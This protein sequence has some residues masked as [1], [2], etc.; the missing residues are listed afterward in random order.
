MLLM[1]LRGRCHPEDGKTGPG[2]GVPGEEMDFP[3]FNV[4][5]LSHLDGTEI[6]SAARGSDLWGWTDSGSG[7]E[8]AI[9]GFQDGTSIVDISVP[10]A[11]VYLGFLPSHTAN[12]AWRDIKTY[13]HFAY[14]VSDTNR[15]HGLQI[16]DLTAV[17]AISPTP[18]VLTETS[19]FSGFSSAHNIAINEASGFAYAVGSELYRGGLVMIDLRQPLEPMIVGGYDGD[20]YTHD[21]QVVIYHGPDADFIGREIA[22]NANEDTL[23]VVDVSDKSEPVLVARTSYP[24]NGYAH[25]GWLTEDQGYFLLNDEL[26]ELRFATV[27]TTR[28]HIFDVRDLDDV[29]YLGLYQSSI[30]SIDHNHYT[31]NGL[32]YQANYT[33]GLRVL[34]LSDVGNVNLLEVGFFDTHPEVDNTS[35]FDGA[36]SVF[37]Y[38]GSGSII[39]ADRERGLFVLELDINKGNQPTLAAASIHVPETAVAGAIAGTINVDNV[40]A[41]NSP[42]FTMDG[43][44]GAALFAIDRNTGHITL[45]DGAVLDFESTMTLELIVN[46]SVAGAPNLRDRQT[47]QI[48]VTDVNEAPI[49]VDDAIHTDEDTVVSSPPL[50]ANDYDPDNADMASIDDD[51]AVI[52]IDTTMT[53]GSV[54]D[55]GG[56]VVAYDP[57]GKFES[58]NDGETA[59]DR[60][61]YTVS[62]DRGGTSVG[63]V[64]VQI[65]GRTDP[66]PWY[67]LVAPS[68]YHGGDIDATG[69]WLNVQICEVID[70]LPGPV[71]FATSIP[72]SIL[73]PIGYVRA[74][75]AG[76]L[77]GVYRYQD[78]T[79]NP[80]TNTF[81]DWRVST[82]D[83]AHSDTRDLTVEYGAARVKAVPE[84]TVNLT[85]NGT[86]E[87][88]AELVYAQG[89]EVQI[90][91]VV[92]PTE[93]PRVIRRL[94]SPDA[95]GFIPFNDAIAFTG[96]LR[97]GTYVV[98]LRAF[99]PLSAAVPQPFVVP[100]GNP[101]IVTSAEAQ[102]VQVRV[103]PEHPFPE[104]GAVLVA[105]GETL[106]VAV[107]WLSVPGAVNYVIYLADIAKG[108][109]LNYTKILND[110]GVLDTAPPVEVELRPGSY[111]WSACAVYDD[112][113]T[114]GPWLP[115][116]R[117]DIVSDLMQP[118]ITN[119]VLVDACSDALLLHMAPGGGAAAEVEMYRFDAEDGWIDLGSVA[120]IDGIAV[121]PDVVFRPGDLIQLRAVQ[122]DQGDSTWKTF[123][124]H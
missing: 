124:L 77:P 49:T 25:Q 37:P 122:V 16:L 83:A 95:D 40:V 67:P 73:R 110:G 108:P 5:L 29:R 26:D 94:Y 27:A 45:R 10:A 43:G 58:L 42:I 81:G 84:P 6:G 8:I 30:P 11:P 82:P 2:S 48:S 69:S 20:G 64:S 103:A 23:T 109:V 106:S 80:V 53:L 7:R 61:Q 90:T 88:N 85:G 66:P 46:V 97:P 19:H 114:H 9:M 119:V 33:S 22:F 38:Y 79:W 54:I 57:N 71:V 113:A 104:T 78:R 1:P 120:V 68:L 63:N 117:F 32:L 51:L 56:G 118:L 18:A 98:A 105:H 72:G 92:F 4:R 41:G 12:S 28:T 123:T 55:L 14:I 112:R 44:T 100:T 75:F 115:A 70:G 3:A 116:Q 59:E 21:T 99:N 74:G 91:D 36:W 17:L 87:L 34:D 47:V 52:A 107:N 31:H 13:R 39:V 86:F 24:E 101:L 111:L 15:D 102:D 89:F 93:P 62:D 60:F 76:L 50:H 96:R 65:T 35:R 121:F